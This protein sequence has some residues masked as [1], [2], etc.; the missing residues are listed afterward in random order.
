MTWGS[1]GNDL[2][3]TQEYLGN[4]GRVWDMTASMTVDSGLIPVNLKLMGALEH[5]L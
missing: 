1:Y 5:S 3:M 2:A 4:S